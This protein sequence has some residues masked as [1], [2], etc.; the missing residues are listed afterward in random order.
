MSVIPL[1]SVECAL[2]DNQDFVRLEGPDR[3]ILI[4]REED[5][6][7]VRDCAS[8]PDKFLDNARITKDSRSVKAGV[9]ALPGGSAVFIKKTKNRG[10]LHT[11]KLALRGP[12]IFRAWK[13]AWGL[14]LC[15]VPTPRPLAALVRWRGRILTA[16]WLITDVIESLPTLEYY[17]LLRR[18]S[19]LLNSFAEAVCGYLA[20]LHECG[21]A[22]GDIKMSNIYCSKSRYDGKSWFFGFWDLDSVKFTGRDLR[23]E[24]KVYDLARLSSSFVELGS[25][26]N[27]KIDMP[28]AIDLFLSPYDKAWGCSFLRSRDIK[29]TAERLLAKTQSRNH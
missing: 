2:E 5:C 3:V 26:L 1:S 10:I 24:E 29:P 22:F 20:T 13:N 21:C 11:L 18:D 9:A 25:R 7:A 8:S 19:K 4:R 28:S 16:S 27:I 14:E 12:R 15:A 17:E 6:D 23:K